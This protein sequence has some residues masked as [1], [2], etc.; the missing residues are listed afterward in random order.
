MRTGSASNNTF[1]YK[2][3]SSNA[4]YVLNLT[5]NEKEKH[6]EMRA[7]GA[8]SLSLPGQLVWEEWVIT[9]KVWIIKERS[10]IKICRN[11]SG[12]IR[13]TPST[14]S[15]PPVMADITSWSQL[16]STPAQ[17]MLLNKQSKHPRQII[18]SWLSL[19]NFV[20]MLDSVLWLR[21]WKTDSH[22]IN[23]GCWPLFRGRWA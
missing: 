4:T 17:E 3:N 5:S 18:W 19:W 14:T 8:L 12:Q 21:D 15:R 9:E 10:I 11:P 7:N 13:G 1:S 23:T 6:P 2:V 22:A 20:A 16:F